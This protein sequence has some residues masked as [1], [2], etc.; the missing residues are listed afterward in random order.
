MPLK[1][2]YVNRSASPCANDSGDSTKLVCDS[3]L[4]VYSF[5]LYQSKRDVY[6]V[7]RGH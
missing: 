5:N 7:F 3:K 6:N 2:V 4:F 1:I